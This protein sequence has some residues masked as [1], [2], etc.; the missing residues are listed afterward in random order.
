MRRMQAAA[1]R[2]GADIPQ[3]L[4]RR[5]SVAA[6]TESGCG[7]VVIVPLRFPVQLLDPELELRPERL[8]RGLF[9]LLLD[10]FDLPF[11]FLELRLTNGR[12]ALAFVRQI[13]ARP[14]TEVEKLDPLLELI[15]P[16]LDAEAV[17][18]TVGRMHDGL[19]NRRL[20]E[21]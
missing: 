6:L 21:M 9:Q 10:L 14:L 8:I 16:H 1:I 11:I 20:A 3:E 19:V 4:D 15:D 18:V 5:R 12:D 2:Q 13:D 17:E 7:H